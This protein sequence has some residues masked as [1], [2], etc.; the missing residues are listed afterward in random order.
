MQQYG[1][2]PRKRKLALY[3]TYGVMTTAVA[4]ISAV[5]IFL[6][7]GYRLD[8]KNGDVEQG[9]LLQLRSFP[10]GAA[11][12]LDNETLSFV[13]PGK[14]NVDVGQH[15]VSMKLKGY[16][17]WEKTVT[18]KAS[19]LRWLNY[20]RL[21]PETVKTI[22]EKEFST[23]VG[24]LPSPDRKWILVQP[25]AE[26]PELTLVDVRDENTPVYSQL[27]LPATSYSEKPGQA[28]QFS[29][30]EWDFGS[31]YVLIKHVMGDVTEYLRLDRTDATETVNVTSKLGVSLQDIHFSGSSGSVF[32]ALENGAIRKL[33]SGAGTISQPLVKDVAAFRLYKTD[34]MAYVKQPLENRVGIGVIVNDKATRVAT[35]DATVPIYVDINEYFND[36]Y[37][38]IG[39]G[40]S[41]T[42]YKDPELSE[43]VKVA[44]VTSASAVNWI[45]LSNNGRFMVAGTGSQFVSYDLETTEKADVNLPGTTP[46]PT[47][48]LQWLDDYYLVSAADSD[49][50]ITEFDGANQQVITSALPGFPVSL[51]NDGRVIYSFTKTQTGGYALQSSLMTVKK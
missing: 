48:P 1:K 39:R 43:R 8:L 32:F 6:V 45:R 16:R 25:S 5:C 4:L 2:S 20:A 47:K 30:V 42:I 18:V 35:Y 33:D 24:T 37:L 27:T 12:S 46:D 22:T 28:H 23:L 44:T 36:H 13:T 3:F 29:L 21:V 11:I 50:R 10:V 34:T 40:T 17:S 51:N 26:K 19:E 7:L 38:A 9:A 31:K 15:T 14:R 41:V 49:L